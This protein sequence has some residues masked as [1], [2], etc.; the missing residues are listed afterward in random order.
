MSDNLETSVLGFPAAAFDQPAADDVHARFKTSALVRHVVIDGFFD[1]QF[2]DEL[3]RGFPLAKE[4]P[5][6]R[7]YMFSDKRELS[8]L[9]THSSTSRQLHDLLVSPEFA[10]FISGFGGEYIIDEMYVGGGFHVGGAG[11]F[12]D[13]HTDFNIHPV[14]PTWHRRLNI[15]LYLNPEWQPAW[16]GQLILTNDPT[17]AGIPSWWYELARA[18]VGLGG[19]TS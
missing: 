3:S 9:D 14:N 11:S 7:D 17:V 18:F 10:R 13:L 15:L 19:M 8:T 1:Q 6:S 2:A 5:K 12:L 4:M 16:G